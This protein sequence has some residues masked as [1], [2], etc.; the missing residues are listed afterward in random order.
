MMKGLELSHAYYENVI[1]PWLKETVPELTER[2]AAG[3]VGDGSECF[4]YDDEYSRDHE[5]GA[6]VCLW[7]GRRDFQ[8]YGE[9][10]MEKWNSLP[11][12]YFGF[13]VNRLPGRNGILETEDFF[14]KYL[15]KPSCPETVG[16][17]LQI[18]EEWLACASNGQ[19]FADPYG[20]FSSVWKDLRMGYPE[21]I[22]L[23]KIAF[24]CMQAGQ[25]G[26]YN[27]PRLILRE[28]CIAAE[29]ALAEFMKETMS[30]AYLLNGKYA[31]FYKWMHRGLRDL[32]ILGNEISWHLKLLLKG[33]DRQGEI[34][35]ICELLIM[36]FHRQGISSEQDFYMVNQGKNI[37]DH[38]ELEGLRRTDPWMGSI[39][40]A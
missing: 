14:R 24:H 22:R 2:V 23:K 25:A 4:G 27:Y 34:E 28:D 10:L 16:E 21:D 5:W 39:N 20:E 36:E 40:V 13:P 3:L 37:H 1:S 31:P 7:L 11:S 26:Q 29:L 8:E 32:N 38:I 18:P 6:S 12:Q 30:I 33:G 9:M 19:V 17:W 35:E 15:N